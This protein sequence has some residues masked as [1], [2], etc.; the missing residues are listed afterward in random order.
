MNRRAPMTLERSIQS[1][2]RSCRCASGNGPRLFCHGRLQPRAKRNSGLAAQSIPCRGRIA[3]INAYL[4]EIEKRN[5]SARTRLAAIWN[6]AR[7]RRQHQF[8]YR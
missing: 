3:A 8:R 1:N 4:H 6:R 7:P 2:P 5:N